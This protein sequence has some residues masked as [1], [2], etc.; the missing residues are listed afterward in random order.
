MLVPSI[1]TYH[2]KVL[3]V[4]YPPSESE[5]YELESDSE[6]SLKTLQAFA[7]SDNPSSQSSSELQSESEKLWENCYMRQNT[8]NWIDREK[9]LC[10]LS[11]LAVF[12]LSTCSKR[13]VKIIWVGSR[14]FTFFSV[15]H[16]RKLIKKQ[17]QCFSHHVF[18]Q[19]SIQQ[20]GTT[21]PYRFSSAFCQMIRLHRQI[22]GGSNRL[23]FMQVIWDI[24][25]RM[26]V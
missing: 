1:W 20:E 24:N 12:L 25:C 13:Y 14:R 26:N 6:S 18:V 19:G 15:N 5:L 16:I 21:Y 11:H 4:S 2:T 9:R 7:F 10:T 22:R 23:W 3:S 17:E 8:Q